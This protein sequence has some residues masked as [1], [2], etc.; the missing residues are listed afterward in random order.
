MFS[1]KNRRKF[2][3]NEYT[4][5]LLKDISVGNYNEEESLQLETYLMQLNLKKPFNVIE[6][7]STELTTLQ[8]QI[9]DFCNIR[10]KHCLHDIKNTVHLPFESIKRLLD[11]AEKMDCVYVNITGGESFMHP[12]IEK[13]IKYAS[14]KFEIRIQT[15]GMLCSEKQ[16]DKIKN[17]HVN[18]FNVSLDGIKEDHEKIRG[19]DTFE[20]ALNGIAIL[21]KYG[22]N[23]EINHVVSTVNVENF[24]RFIDFCKSNN[25]NQINI[26]PIMEY[27]CAVQ[28]KDIILP[29]KK[30]FDT[31]NI[32]Y[33]NDS[34]LKKRE[35]FPC[36]AGICN[37]YILANGD[38][39]PCIEFTEYVQGNINQKS[40]SEIY[41]KF[42]KSFS[43]IL[44]TDKRN[45]V[46]C[47][48]C[49]ELSNCNYGCRG[50]AKNEGDFWGI[51]STS[52][53]FYKTV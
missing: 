10:C 22:F 25:L 31:L 30:V 33:S 40:Y 7:K 1:L 14:Q 50:R 13:I 32:S 52:C 12:D 43:E 16:I 18:S 26:S 42:P 51:D 53:S 9:T 38:V 19:T 11:D 23:V 39:I 36:G 5:N 47:H 21:Q 6:K 49:K 44:T 4:I 46:S 35:G 24:E 20:K 41:M 2:I 29:P 15:N 17:C 3:A 48:E 37:N 28:N 45:F 34:L 8:I 27:G